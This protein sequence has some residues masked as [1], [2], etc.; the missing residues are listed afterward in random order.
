MKYRN[1]LDALAE[2]LLLK[3]ELVESEIESILGAPA[4]KKAEP[5]SGEKESADSEGDAQPEEK[6][7]SDETKD[8]D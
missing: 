4:Y 5:E 2:A 7:D 3:E 1:K 8:K 6:S